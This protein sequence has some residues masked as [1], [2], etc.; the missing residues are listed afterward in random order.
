MGLKYDSPVDP[1]KSPAHGLFP[2]EKGS[3]ATPG[4]RSSLRG[5]I[6]RITYQNPQGPYTV[7]RLEGDGF[8]AVTLVGG[9]YPISEGE[10][11]LVSGIWKTHPRYGLQFQVEQWQKIEPATLKGIERYLGSGL[12]KGLGPV[13][14]RRLVSRFGLDTLRILSQEPRRLLEVEGIGKGRWGKIIQAWEIQKGTCN[15]S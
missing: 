4:E 7:A 15:R 6:A 5:T 3:L 9:L 8:Q 14:A 11:V 1:K 13:Y 10:E 2:V 12:I